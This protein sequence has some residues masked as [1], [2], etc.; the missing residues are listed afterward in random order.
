MLHTCVSFLHVSATE[1]VSF[2]GSRVV[3]HG[4]VTLD[5]IM[6]TSATALVCLTPA[7]NCC[8]APGS[9]DWV[10]PSGAVVATSTAASIYQSRGN[11]SLELRRN[12][13]GEEGIYR[14]DV[15]LSAGAALSSFYVGVYQ[16][17]SGRWMDLAVQS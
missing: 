11:S 5:K 8:T 14:C 6:N 16:D 13:G 3:S 9:G 2:N 15:R 4:I 17:G 1:G 7:Q 10:S 12:S